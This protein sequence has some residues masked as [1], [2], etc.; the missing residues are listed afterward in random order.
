[1]NMSY[2]EGSG[3]R[4]CFPTAPACTQMLPKA[5]VRAKT[6]PANQVPTAVLN[7]EICCCYMGDGC[8]CCDYKGWIYY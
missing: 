5:R 7:W 1:M 8:E 6:N 3:Y 4:I 2:D